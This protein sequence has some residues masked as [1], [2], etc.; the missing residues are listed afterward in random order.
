MKEIISK[1]RTWLI[2][3]PIPNTSTSCNKDL[4]GGYGT[5][6]KIGNN[7]LSK[8]IARLKKKNIKLK[9]KSP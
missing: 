2:S 9:S 3:N 5:W 7:L 6:D 4:N 8:F 1:E